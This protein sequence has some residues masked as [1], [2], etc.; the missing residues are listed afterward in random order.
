MDKTLPSQRRK[1]N[2]QLA[3]TQ[4]HF[5]FEDRR[6]VGAVIVTQIFVSELGGDVAI[7]GCLWAEGPQEQSTAVQPCGDGLRRVC[8]L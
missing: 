5:L 8:D 7:I 2:P 4:S 1:G 6:E 3:L